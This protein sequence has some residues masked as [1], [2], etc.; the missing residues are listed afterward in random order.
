MA[1]IVLAVHHRCR[2][3]QLAT[4]HLF[5]WSSEILGIP[6]FLKN[7]CFLIYV[8]INTSKITEV[9]LG[10]IHQINFESFFSM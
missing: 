7:P 5:S 2:L 6:C 4:K 1:Y 3:P 9:M 8:I 10:Y